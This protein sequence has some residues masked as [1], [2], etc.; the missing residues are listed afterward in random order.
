MRIARDGLAGLGKGR[1]R[2]CYCPAEAGVSHASVVTVVRPP[3][4][5]NSASLFLS[6]CQ[7]NFMKIEIHNL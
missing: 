6:F 1:V 2:S 5:L 3:E 4:I 7:M